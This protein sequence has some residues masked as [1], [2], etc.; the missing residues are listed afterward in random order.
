MLCLS[1][2]GWPM[3]LRSWSYQAL[4]WGV[5]A[6]GCDASAMWTKWITAK[7]ANSTSHSQPNNDKCCILFSE[8]SSFKKAVKQI[9]IGNL[10]I[11][12]TLS[13]LVTDIC[14]WQIGINIW[15]AKKKIEVIVQKPANAFLK[16][17]N[18]VDLNMRKE[19][20]NIE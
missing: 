20:I 12:N 19:T 8:A 5:G 7:R 2:R 16:K 13:P 9:K 10:S 1:K 6:G 4:C 15:D 3:S 11:N 17:Q 18:R 14:S